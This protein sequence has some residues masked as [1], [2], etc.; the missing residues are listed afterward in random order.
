MRILAIGNSFSQDSTAHLTRLAQAGGEDFFVLNLY[1]GGCSLKRHW[2][3]MKANAAEYD[4]QFHGEP[5]GRKMSIDEALAEGPW[6]VV[7]LQQAS[8][9][10]GLWDSYEPYLTELAAHVR[11]KAPQAKLWIHQTWAYEIDSAH[12]EFVRYDHD[13]KKMYAALKDAYSRAAAAIEAPMIPCGDLIQTLRGLAPFD[14]AAGG[15]SL[16]RDGFHMDLIYGRYAIAAL[17]YSCLTGRDVREN[18]YI[19]CEEASADMLALVRET[20]H[21]IANR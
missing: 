18:T 15:H 11:E 10:S 1:I 14:Y 4:E 16:C 6:D 3:N 21:G 5:T 17:W 13:Q 2:E 20:V 19:P 7:T 12:P 8:H 9:D